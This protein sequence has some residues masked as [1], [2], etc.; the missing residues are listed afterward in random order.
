MQPKEH[1]TGDWHSIRLAR[2]AG[3]WQVSWPDPRALIPLPV[4]SWLRSVPKRP[5]C[6]CASCTTKCINDDNCGPCTSRTCTGNPPVPW[7]H[8]HSISFRP[9]QQSHVSGRSGC[10]QRGARM[11]A[12]P[13]VC[14][15][16]AFSGSTMRGEGGCYILL[17]FPPAQP[18]A[19]T[20]AMAHVRSKRRAIFKRRVGSTAEL[21]SADSAPSRSSSL[22]KDR[23]SE[24]LGPAKHLRHAA[25][26][27]P[28]CVLLTTLRCGGSC[29]TRL[30]G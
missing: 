12:R 25:L 28:G 20:R 27:L 29:V 8:S 1:R 30:W 18:R 13:R 26:L 14:A 10:R 19:L 9:L 3:A 15:A 23:R 24:S 2:P 22:S 6:R 7:H 17:L 4:S 16:E 11:S 5:Q 21:S